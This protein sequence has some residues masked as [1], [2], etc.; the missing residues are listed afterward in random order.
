MMVQCWEQ[1]PSSRPTFQALLDTAQE[2]LR[3]ERNS[4]EY[5]AVCERVHALVPLFPSFPPPPPPAAPSPGPH[6]RG[7]RTVLRIV[8]TTHTRAH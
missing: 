2:L 5:A 6:P 1:Q 4:A 8:A 3:R 7:G